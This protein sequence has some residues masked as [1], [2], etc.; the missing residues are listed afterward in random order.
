MQVRGVQNYPLKYC[1]PKICYC[2][3]QPKE[4]ERQ[5]KKKLGGPW[6]TQAPLRIATGLEGYGL[7]YITG[8]M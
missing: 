7:D 5:I 3:C 4:L 8:K 6:P 1:W 2:I